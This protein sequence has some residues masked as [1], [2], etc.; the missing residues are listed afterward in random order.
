MLPGETNPTAVAALGSQRLRATPDQLC[1]ALGLI[2]TPEYCAQRIMDMTR[3]GVTNLY[4]MPLQT[5]VGPE[6][7]IA[8]AVHEVDRHA[9]VTQTAQRCRNGLRQCAVVIVADPAFEQVAEYVE[10]LR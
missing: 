7:E 9:A 10:R 2:G 6:Q 8:I 5:F 3:V 4:L 1:D